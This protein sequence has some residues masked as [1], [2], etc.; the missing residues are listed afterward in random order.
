MNNDGRNLR[1]KYYSN[2]GVNP[3]PELNPL[4][5][6]G[7]I[8]LLPDFTI[9]PPFPVKKHTCPICRTRTD[10]AKFTCASCV[11]NGIEQTHAELDNLRHVRQ[12]LF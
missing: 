4:S 2:L 11:R 12:D 5:K 9:S 1:A 8:D 3:S 6:S 10:I 7:D